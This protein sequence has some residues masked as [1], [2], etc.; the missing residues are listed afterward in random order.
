MRSPAEL[1]RQLESDRENATLAFEMLI[2]VHHWMEQSLPVGT[3][4]RGEVERVLIAARRFTP[5]KAKKK[6]K[7]PAVSA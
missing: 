3:P 6:R 5:A 4:I 1:S 2:K 7:K